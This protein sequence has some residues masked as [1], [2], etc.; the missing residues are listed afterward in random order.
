MKNFRYAI[1]AGG[2]A[3]FGLMILTLPQHSYA[4]AA[5]EI[6]VTNTA[7][8]PVPTKNVE[9]AARQSY[10]LGFNVSGAS[11]S[12]NIPAGKIFVIE[13]VSAGLSTVT[14]FGAATPCRILRLSF[15]SAPKDPAN[16]E[17]FHFVPVLLGSTSGIGGEVSFYTISQPV[18]IYAM[19][20]WIFAASWLAGPVCGGTGIEGRMV[21]SG[22]LVAAN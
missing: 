6:Q 11:D 18:K 17:A 21:L 4:Q 8:N 14:P 12:P 19:P 9:N 16:S 5:H 7:A 1:F 10:Q 2:I 3:L 20:E 15:D 13:Y 22:Y